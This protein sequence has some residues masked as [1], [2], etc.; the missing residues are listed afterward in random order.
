MQ[1]D[2]MRENRCKSVQKLP[3]V[4]FKPKRL[5][6]LVLAKQCIFYFFKLDIGAS[7]F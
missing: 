5:E 2:S 6:N 3:E 1:T 4:F 7:M